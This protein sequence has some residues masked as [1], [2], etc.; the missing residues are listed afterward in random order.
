[1]TLNDMTDTAALVFTGLTAACARCHDH[2]F[3]P[4]SQRDYY[5]LQAFFTPARFRRDL[6][7][8]DAPA[9]AAFEKQRLAYEKRARPLEAERRKIEEPYLKTL[10]EKKLAR[11]GEE[12]RA[13][14][15]TAPD[16]RT[17]AQRE[18]VAKTNR[19]IAVAPQEVLRALTPDD[20]K[21][22]DA[23]QKQLRA[24]DSHRPR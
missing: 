3:E 7:I 21:R 11:L 5:R 2:K 22:H 4:I 8:A 15:A 6:V 10:K 17:T 13:A 23:L 14:H 9:R 19:L 18:L 1:N 20:R 24:L 12:A 16:K